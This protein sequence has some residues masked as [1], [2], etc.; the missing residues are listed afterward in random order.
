MLVLVNGCPGESGG[1]PD[2]SGGGDGYRYDAGLVL[3]DATTDIDRSVDGASTQ[4]DQGQPK[5]LGLPA[6]SEAQALDGPTTTSGDVGDPCVY[7]EQ[8]KY[9][10][11]AGNTHTGERFC[12]KVCDPCSPDPCPVGSGCQDAGMAFICAPGYPNAPCN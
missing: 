12:T 10:F 11:C 6:D 4:S 1:L 2:G 5:D 8:C 9:G 3:V 7:N